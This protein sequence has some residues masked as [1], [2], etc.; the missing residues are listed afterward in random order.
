MALIW[1][2]TYRVGLGGKVNTYIFPK[3]AN[4]QYYLEEHLHS[5]RHHFEHSDLL[6]LVFIH[7][8]YKL[9]ST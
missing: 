3:L 9:V 1:S 7:S 4:I 2:H 5:L 6:E 8:N